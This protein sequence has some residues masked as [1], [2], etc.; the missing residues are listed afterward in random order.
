MIIKENRYTAIIEFE[1]I[2]P[3]SHFAETKG[4]KLKLSMFGEFCPD[5]SLRGYSLLF[6]LDNPLYYRISKIVEKGKILVIPAD[7]KQNY[8]SDISTSQLING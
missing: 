7:R 2:K 8:A 3:N 4:E 5:N 6:L 1:V